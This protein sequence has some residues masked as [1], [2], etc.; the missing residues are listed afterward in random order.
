MMV[1]DRQSTTEAAI[2][3]SEPMMRGMSEADARTGR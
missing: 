3:P 1:A 2:A